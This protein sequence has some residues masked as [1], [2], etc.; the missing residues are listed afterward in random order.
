[1]LQNSLK[2]YFQL[3]TH[4]GGHATLQNCIDAA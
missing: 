3:R 2:N 1:M 4:V